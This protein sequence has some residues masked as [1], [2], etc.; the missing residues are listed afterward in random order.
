M[1]RLALRQPKILDQHEIAAL[2]VILV[3]QDVTGVGRNA[4]PTVEW[5]LRHYDRGTPMRSE[6]EE[7]NESLLTGVRWSAVVDPFRSDSVSDREA[8][9]WSYN[10]HRLPALDRHAPDFAGV[11]QHVIKDC[12]AIRRFC[13]VVSCTR[14]SNLGCVVSLNGHFP[15]LHL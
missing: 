8:L 5:M 6:A 14:S 12:L 9:G 10:P 7:S 2:L 13:G 11:P 4:H 1:N 15:D 3:K